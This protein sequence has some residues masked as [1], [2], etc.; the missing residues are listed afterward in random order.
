MAF[1][2]EDDGLVYGDELALFR[3]P[4]TNS[5]VEKVR[6]IEYR[7][8]SQSG[9]DGPVEFLITGGGNQYIDLRRTKLHVKI[10]LVKED[11]K[12]L[13]EGENVGCIN[14]LLHSLWGQVDVHLQQKLISSSG[15]MYPFKAYLDTLLRYGTDDKETKVQSQMYYPDT[16]HAINTSDILKGGNSGL[17]SRADL[18]AKSKLIDLEGPLLSD[19]CQM[20]RYLLNGIET[21]FKLW[22]SNN[23]FRVMSGVVDAKYKVVVKD[24]K[25]SV[26]HV[27]VSPEIV[28]GHN[29]IL[30]SATAKYP[31]W[32]SEIKHFAV[33]SGQYYFNK[34]NI[35]QGEVP[36]KMIMGLVSSKAMSGDYKKN[37]FNF[38]HYNVDNIA[39]TVDGENIP[40]KPL[41]PKFSKDKGQNFITAYN[42]LFS[43]KDDSG[44]FKGISRS[45]YPLGYTLY[46]FDLEPTLSKVDYW[47]MLKRGNLKLDIHFEKPLTETVEVLIYATFPDLFE[48]DGSRAVL[49]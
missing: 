44:Q 15:A 31:F 8:I 48:V 39:I 29:E 34:D 12:S 46:V 36:T 45:D 30:K 22:P 18:V 20:S 9:D 4:P 16:S 38:Q 5:G 21:S 23:S 42:T 14:L 26:C 6:W 47:P 35:F 13:E 25:L 32:R 17:T 11:G 28:M 7:P 37:P 10:K 40:G 33:S 27:T 1:R 43:G 49:R 2:A 19:V 24:A 41:T 3:V